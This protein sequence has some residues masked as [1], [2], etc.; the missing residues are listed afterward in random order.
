M[1]VPLPQTLSGPL[2]VVLLAASWHLI[3][4]WVEDC[5][6]YDEPDMLVSIETE[7]LIQPVP[8]PVT[9]VTCSW[10]PSTLPVSASTSTVSRLTPSAPMPLIVDSQASRAALPSAATTTRLV[11]STLVTDF[12]CDLATEAAAVSV[13][14]GVTESSPI[15]ADCATEV[16]FVAPLESVIT[17]KSPPRTGRLLYVR[18]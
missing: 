5:M 1:P 17:T 15:G 3:V 12:S 16:Y 9:S 11:P 7:P 4:D 14:F 10:V 8:V 13:I 18:V 2:N 6:M